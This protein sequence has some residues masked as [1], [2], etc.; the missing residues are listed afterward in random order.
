MMGSPIQKLR[1]LKFCVIAFSVLM[2]N[3]LKNNNW[4]MIYVDLHLGDNLDGSPNRRRLIAK[5]TTYGLELLWED[6]NWG[7]TPTQ[8]GT[9]KTKNP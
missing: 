8:E 6:M 7:V 9:D 5:K 2:W 4:H 3:T 1:I